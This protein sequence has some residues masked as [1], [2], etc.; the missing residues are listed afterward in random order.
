VNGAPAERNDVSRET[1]VIGY[2]AQQGIV[3]SWTAAQ[4]I[5]DTNVRSKPATVVAG[6]REDCE[7]SSLPPCPAS[8]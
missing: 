4:S 5:L 2:P 1:Q 6:Q 7:R 8:R 3:Q